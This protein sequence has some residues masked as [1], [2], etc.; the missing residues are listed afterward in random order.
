MDRH[1]ELASQFM[2][3]RRSFPYIKFDKE[4]SECSR[5][6]IYILNYL[7]MHNGEAHPKELS[8]ELIVSSARMA[9]LLNQLEEKEYIS[10]IRDEHDNRQ[11]VIRLMEAGA[12]FFEK[13]NNKALKLVAHFF[14]ELGY[15]DAEEFV[16]LYSRLMNFISEE[17]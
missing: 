16:A 13:S 5:Y 11:T 14:D 10:R 7:S 1:I 17:D 3:M 15:E 6:E 4:V 9:V 12:D 8:D 2:Q